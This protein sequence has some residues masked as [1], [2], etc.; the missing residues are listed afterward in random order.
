[1]TM[2]YFHLAILCV[3]LSSPNL[4]PITKCCWSYEPYVLTCPFLSDILQSCWLEYQIPP[5]CREYYFLQY[6]L[7]WYYVWIGIPWN[8]YPNLPA[9]GKPFLFSPPKRTSWDGDPGDPE[10]RVLL[11]LYMSIQRNF[12]CGATVDDIP[13]SKL[14]HWNVQNK[15]SKPC[16]FQ[17]WIHLSL[18]VISILYVVDRFRS[19][20]LAWFSGKSTQ[21]PHSNRLKHHELTKIKA[22]LFQLYKSL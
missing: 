7:C 21:I 16:L 12:I 14:E 8:S 10:I 18:L 15:H 22:T 4:I 2:G 11:Q 5:R 20:H 6:N 13:K 17:D 19:I 1:M 3:Y 9:C